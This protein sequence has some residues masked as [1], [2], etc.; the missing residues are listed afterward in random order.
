M[1]EFFYPESARGIRWDD[2]ALSIRWPLRDF[3]VSAKDRAYPLL[4]GAGS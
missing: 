3:I 2:P 4:V 1:S